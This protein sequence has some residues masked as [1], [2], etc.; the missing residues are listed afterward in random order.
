MGQ[1]LHVEQQGV[2]NPAKAV[3]RPC[4]GGWYFGPRFFVAAF[5]YPGF[6]FLGPSDD[7][8]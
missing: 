6:R 3:A 2:I 8:G 1:R 4:Q 7:G 5:V